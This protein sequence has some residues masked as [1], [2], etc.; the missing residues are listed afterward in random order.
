MSLNEKLLL[1]GILLG[2]A[3]LVGIASADLD[4]GNRLLARGS[5]LLILIGFLM[6]FGVI[7]V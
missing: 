1:S 4:G 3:G 2:L 7:W 5:G 6:F